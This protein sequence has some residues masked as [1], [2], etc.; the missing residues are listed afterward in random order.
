[1]E[2]KLG[3]SFDITV[4][5]ISANQSNPSGVIVLKHNNIT[6]GVKVLN[7]EGYVVF[8]ISS[9]KLGVGQHTLVA[10]YAGDKK[11]RAAYS[12]SYEIDVVK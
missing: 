12:F 4:S 7:S 11:N 9:K 3:K 2:I 5:V 8:N 6:L 10:Y 1:M